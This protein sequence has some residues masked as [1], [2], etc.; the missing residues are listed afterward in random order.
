MSSLLDSVVLAEPTISADSLAPIYPSQYYYDHKCAYRFVLS[1]ST[2]VVALPATPRMELGTIIHALH[3][4]AFLNRRAGVTLPQAEQKF[5]ELVAVTQRRLSASPLSAHLVPL[6]SSCDV[7][8]ARRH[9]AVRHAV[10]EP[11]AMGAVSARRSRLCSEESIVGS[12]A[13]IKGTMDTVY[14]SGDAIDIIDRK[15]GDVTRDGVLRESYVTQLKLYAGLVHDVEGIMPRSLAIIDGAFRRHEV[16]FTPDEVLALYSAAKQ[17]LGAVR[18]EVSTRPGNLASLADPRPSNCKYCQ[19]RPNCAPYWEAV[20]QGAQGY[21][22]DFVSIVDSIE[23]LAK[24]TIV[25]FG[26]YDRSLSFRIKESQ[27]SAYKPTLDE[28]KKGDRILIMNAI[29]GGRQIEVDAQTVILIDR[30]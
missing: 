16:A 7:Y 4:W 17:W 6:S 19:L 13:L 8:I 24:S 2:N 27:L 3:H 28:L 10:R 22:M 21:P 12:D 20:R 30:R 9:S 23:T 25:R 11:L 26:G 1:R 29:M 5:E 14:F 15:S 18:E